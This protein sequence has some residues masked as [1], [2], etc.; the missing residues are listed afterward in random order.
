MAD[1]NIM[2]VLGT[3]SGVELTDATAS[4][5]LAN[6]SFYFSNDGRMTVICRNAHASAAATLTI[7]TPKALDGLDLADRVVSINA[8]DTVAISQL[9]PDVYNGAGPSNAGSGFVKMDFTG[10]PAADDLQLYVIRV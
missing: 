1:I 6:D 5:T 4:T 3:S 2:P 9:T 8:G 10:T 7:R